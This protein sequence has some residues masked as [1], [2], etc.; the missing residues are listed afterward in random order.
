MDAL[1][2]ANGLPTGTIPNA[3][4]YLLV[5]T[6]EQ[7]VLVDT[8]RGGGVLPSLNTLGIG[9]DDIDAVVVSHFHGDHIGG[10]WPTA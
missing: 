1:L 6:G 7:L 4:Q 2:A 10:W 9:A 8:G 5:N 3:I